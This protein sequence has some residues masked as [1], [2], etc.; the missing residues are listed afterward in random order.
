MQSKSIDWFLYHNDVREEK[1]KGVY[2][3]FHLLNDSWT[4]LFEFVTRGFELVT[5]EFELM[6][7][8]S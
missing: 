7:L 8:I 3:S 5:R 2:L 6:D 4:P 1:V